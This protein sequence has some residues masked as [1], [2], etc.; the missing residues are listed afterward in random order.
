MDYFSLYVAMGILLVTV[1]AINVSR[2][3]VKEKIGN[4][5]GENPLLKKAIRTHMNA[6][7]HI[8]PFSIILLA[9]TRVQ[10]SIQYLA[11]FSIGF[12]L[13]RLLHSY[14]MLWSKFKLRQMAAILTYLFEFLGCFVI[15]INLVMV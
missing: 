12:I 14:S 7:E 1:L 8:L 4:G 10:L 9:L 15:L 6:L 2:I 13:I 3:R 11:I 5:D